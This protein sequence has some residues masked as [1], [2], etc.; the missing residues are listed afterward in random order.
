MTLPLPAVPSRIVAAPMAGGPS[1]VAL[2]A[3][4]CDRRRPFPRRRLPHR[5]AEARRRRGPSGAAAHRSASTCSRRRRTAPRRPPLAY[6]ERLAPMAAASGSSWASRGTPTTTS[7]RRSTCWWSGPGR[8]VVRLRPAAGRR[9]RPAAGR[10]VAVWVTVTSPQDAVRAPPRART[11]SSARAGRPALTAAGCRR[12][13]GA[14]PA[15]AA[16]PGPPGDR[17]A[18]GGGRRDRRRRRR[19]ARGRGRLA[20]R[21]RDGVP[22]TPEAGTAPVHRPRWPRPPTVV[23]RAFTGRPARALVNEASGCSGRTPPRP[24]PRCTC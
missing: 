7:P 16:A 17:A 4:A 19:A 14:R 11:R 21:P 9:G 2:A 12:R 10:R 23:T 22:A 8:R 6:A 5:G 24:T 13:A 15:A 18:A 3:A 1:T 20:G